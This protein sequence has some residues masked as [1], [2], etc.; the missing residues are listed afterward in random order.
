MTRLLALLVILTAGT[1]HAGVCLSDDEEEAGMKEIEAFAKNK[2][3]KQDMES[4][5]GFLCLRG[6]QRYKARLEKACTAITKRDGVYGDCMTNAALVGITSLA[7]HDVYTW[8][9]EI[10][11]DPIAN[12]GGLYISK[13]AMLAALGDK[14]GREIIIDMWTEASPRADKKAKSRVAMMSWASWRQSAATALGKLGTKDDIAFLDEQAAATKDR[15]VAK[16]CRDAIK[17]IAKRSP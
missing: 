1:A 6:D 7:D 15:Y 10:K 8:V 5:Y 4:S 14:R 11:E 9:T 17:M 16:A 12:P 3:K 2:A 13:P